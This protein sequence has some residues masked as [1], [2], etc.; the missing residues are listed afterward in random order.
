MS[1]GGK[2]GFPRSGEIG[3]MLCAIKPVG[4]MEGI[5]LACAYGSRLMLGTG[6]GV[7]ISDGER[8]R[9]IKKVLCTEA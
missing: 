3:E 4:L 1:L 7:V 8:D 5:L 9:G 6:G 2:K